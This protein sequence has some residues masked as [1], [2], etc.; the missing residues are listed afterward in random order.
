MQGGGL[1]VD[2]DVGDVPARADEL[3]AQL[4]LRHADRLDDH[5]GAIPTVSS[6][7]TSTGLS[8]AETGYVGATRANLACA[9]QASLEVRTNLSQSS[10]IAKPGAWTLPMGHLTSTPPLRITYTRG[11]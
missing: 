1:A 4:G 6:S 2:A 5:V 10:P 8:L 7:T 9:L 3:G 11:L